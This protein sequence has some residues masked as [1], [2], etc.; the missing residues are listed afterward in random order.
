VNNH[1]KVTIE[2]TRCG[3]VQVLES[4]ETSV[5]LRLTAYAMQHLACPEKQV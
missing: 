2:C 5:Q 3:D 4:H 1:L